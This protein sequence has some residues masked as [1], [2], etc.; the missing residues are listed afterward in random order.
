MD[1]E[2]ET[3][4]VEIPDDLYQRIKVEADKEGL[5]VDEWASQLLEK[6]LADGSME[7]II[8]QI[9]ESENHD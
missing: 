1:E 2:Y 6:S 4:E 3:L 7:E 9:K 8:K 5:T